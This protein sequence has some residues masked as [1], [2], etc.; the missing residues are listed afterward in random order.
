MSEWLRSLT[1]NQ[2]GSARTGSNPVARASFFV[3]HL[4]SIEQIERE[5]RE[6]QNEDSTPDSAPDDDD[7]GETM[8]ENSTTTTTSTDRDSEKTVI[9]NDDD[10]NS[11]IIEAQQVFNTK[12]FLIN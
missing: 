10:D 9:N 8:V 7:G 12:Y 3:R 1:R 5:N 2:M 6:R 11:Q 4:L